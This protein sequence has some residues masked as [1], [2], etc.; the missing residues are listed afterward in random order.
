MEET[1][2]ERL[3]IA[4]SGRDAFDRELPES[5]SRKSTTE[6]RFGQRRPVGSTSSQS[7]GSIA[8]SMLAS[9]T[10][11]RHGPRNRSNPPRRRASRPASAS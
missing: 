4:R 3:P 2:G 1:I 10:A 8:G 7:P 6:P 11:T 9:T 5:G